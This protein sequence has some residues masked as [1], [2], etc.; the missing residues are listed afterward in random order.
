MRK[1]NAASLSRPARYPDNAVMLSLGR[2]PWT[3]LAR[4]RS[5][6]A[7]GRG[8]TQD[9]CGAVVADGDPRGCWA[10]YPLGVYASD[11]YVRGTVEPAAWVRSGIRIPF[12]GTT[13]S[14]E[15]HH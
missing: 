12:Q 14:G 2:L 6:Q 5:G 15:Q 8:W 9:I 1:A 7:S 13:A 11:V 4:C 10:R 3:T